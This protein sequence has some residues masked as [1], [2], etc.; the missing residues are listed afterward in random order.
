MTDHAARLHLRHH[1]RYA[2]R[3]GSR[4]APGIIQF[5]ETKRRSQGCLHTLRRNKDGRL[6]CCSSSRWSAVRGRK[7]ACRHGENRRCSRKEW[8]QVSIDGSR[9]DI[10]HHKTYARSNSVSHDMGDKFPELIHSDLSRPKM[11]LD[12][13]KKGDSMH[14]HTNTPNLVQG[15]MTP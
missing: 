12:V 15:F 13:I 1:P 4:S 6:A 9:I 11:F 7:S 5:Q 2:C 3:Q 8:R 10:R 14:V